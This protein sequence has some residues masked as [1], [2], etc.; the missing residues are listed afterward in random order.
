MR[1]A[2]S[3]LERQHDSKPGRD[4]RHAGALANGRHHL[5]FARDAGEIGG[6]GGAERDGADRR[7][8]ELLDR[9]IHLV[10]VVDQTRLKRRSC[11]SSCAH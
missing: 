9:A 10:E 4:Q 8:G 7:I 11:R 6:P 2:P 3:V 5:G 1:R